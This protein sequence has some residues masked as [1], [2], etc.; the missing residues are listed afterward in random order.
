[1]NKKP[2]QKPIE[3]KFIRETFFIDSESIQTVTDSTGNEVTKFRAY[4]QEIDKKNLNKRIYTADAV[5]EAVKE[6]Q[7]PIK[8]GAVF[9]YVNHPNWILG[10]DIEK[11]G[12]VVTKVD[13]ENDVVYIEGNFAKTTAFKNMMA[14]KDAG[15]KLG[16]SARGY[17][18][19]PEENPKYDEKLDAYVFGK[20]YRIDGWDFVSSPAVKKAQ[21]IAMEEIEEEQEEVVKEENKDLNSQKPK[22]EKVMFKTIEE[23]RANYPELVGQLDSKLATITGEKEAS[24]KRVKELETSLTDAVKKVEELSK[25]LDAINKEKAAL[26]VKALAATMLADNKY[27]KH[28]VVPDSITTED[29][30]KAFIDAETKKFDAVLAEAGKTVDNKE[31]IV[32]EKPKAVADKV[33]P[34]K[35]TGVLDA[36][37]DTWIKV[38]NR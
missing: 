28:I 33:E 9:A 10:E 13:I 3:D 21:V 20:G 24:D 8:D 32:P 14:V 7:K 18:L 35:E 4:A 29:A 19:N 17:V 31:V 6:V 38:L 22:E 30:L 23:L 16:I 37:I 34:K 11:I 1:M 27:A 25:T 26:T 36:Q 15:G 5:H 12:A 2:K